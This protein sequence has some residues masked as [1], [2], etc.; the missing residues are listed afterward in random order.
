VYASNDG[1]LGCPLTKDEVVKLNQ[2]GICA[3][4]ASIDISYEPKMFATAA[5]E[6]AHMSHVSMAL[7]SVSIDDSDCELFIANTPAMLATVFAM[8]AAVT[9]G[10][11][12]GL[13]LST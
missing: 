4:L 3:K 8:I 12:K 9:V 2:D 6:G 11:S 5:T 7:G 10:R 13:M 1:N